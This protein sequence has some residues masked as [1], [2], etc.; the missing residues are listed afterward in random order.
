MRILLILLCLLPLSSQ[1]SVNVVTSIQPLYLVTKSIMQGVAEPKLLIKSTASVHDFAF[2][3]SQMRLL[4]ETDLVIWIDRNFESGFQKLPDIIS[5]DTVG[6]ELL[7]S[8]DLKQQEGHIWYSP[9]LLLQIIDRIQSTLGRIDP[10]NA[11]SYKRNSAELSELIEAWGKNTRTQLTPVKPRYLLDH[12]FFS[13]FEKHMEVKSIAALHDAN[14]QSP[15]IREL[16]R[17]ED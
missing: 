12:D 1:A 6:L 2:K 15:S 3:P 10:E 5:R 14:E 16:Q 11:G 7:R 9:V 13:H 4:K 8:L 17:I